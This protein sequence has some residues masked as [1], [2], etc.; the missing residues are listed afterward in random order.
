MT[1]T[2]RVLHV[3]DS[4]RD[5]A[6]LTRHL[7]S[8]GYDLISERVET[9]ATMR[10]ALETQTWD[11]ILCDFRMPHFS[12]LAALALL[13]EMQL[14]IPFIII[15]GTVGEAK[16]VEAM[17][18]GAQDYL[19]KDNLARLVPAIE[20]ELVEAANR[21]A[22]QQAEAALRASEAELR[23]LFAAMTDVILVFDAEGR[24][25]KIAPTDPTYLYKPPAD[26]LGKTL[27]E[28]FPQAQADFFLAHIRRA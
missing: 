16:A 18:A 15:S 21:H 19:M 8:A 2:L 24:Y 6:L 3:E 28:V 27:H 26:L 22:R 17:R 7:T 1:K 5:V 4:E 23:A 11:V 12:A 20:R 9:A 10:A 25:L 13:H 14:D